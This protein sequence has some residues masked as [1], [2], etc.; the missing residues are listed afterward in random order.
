MKTLA[1]FGA[2][3]GIGRAVAS[4]F[5]REGYQ[6]AL[7]ARN[8]QRLEQ[9]VDDVAAEGVTAAAFPANLSGR[10]AVSSAVTAIVDRFGPVDVREYSPLPSHDRLVPAAEID[11]PSAQATL[12]T[13]LVGAVHAAALVLPP[14]LERGEGALLFPQGASARSP[15]S[16]VANVGMAMAG[17]RSWIS[18]LHEELKPRGVYVGTVT[19]AAAVVRGAD[20]AN[21]LMAEPDDIAERRWRLLQARDTVEEFV[22]DPNL[23]V[24]AFTGREAGLLFQESF[25]TGWRLGLIHHPRLGRRMIM[26][27]H[28]EQ[29]ESQEQAVLREV[30]EESGLA[31][32]LVNRLTLPLPAGYPHPQVAQPW[33]INEMSVPAD[34]HLAVAHVH[35]DHQYVA[36]ADDP[37]PQA[38]AVHALMT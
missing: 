25:P 5:G 27:G 35:V 13:F 11:A 9:M 30:T 34:N 32:R 4:R 14:M 21:A 8:E 2:G 23:F 7:V 36:I 33:W 22:G 20:P 3:P 18:C 6:I 19:I 24:D 16:F 10:S 37:T 15:L 29:D 38:G 17:L 28:V 1:V 26:G 12:D 31:V